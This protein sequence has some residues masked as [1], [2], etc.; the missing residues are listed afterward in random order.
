MCIYPIYFLINAK[1][2]PGE[3]DFVKEF[4][5]C[6]YNLL[7]YPPYAYHT[8]TVMRRPSKNSPPKLYPD[9]Q[10]LIALAREIV[11]AA[12]RLERRVWE[13][14]MDV[15]I[16]KLLKTGRQEALDAA[17]DHLFKSEI[18]AYDALLQTIEAASESCTLEHDGVSYDVL[19]IAAP[20]LAWTRFAIP[21]GPISPDIQLALTVQLT[22]HV[23]APDV[24]VFVAPQLFS[25]D[26]LPYSHT[27]TSVVTH[28]LAK[29]ALTG[30]DYRP[31]PTLQETPPFLADTRY[32]LAAVAAPAGSP[33]FCWQTAQNP[34]AAVELRVG[35]LKAWQ[36]QGGANVAR[37]LPGCGIELMLPE[38][39]FAACRKADEKIRPASIRAAVHYLTHTLGIEPSSLRAVIAPFGEM[40][41]V[42][43]ASEFR[44]AFATRD[45]NDIV[46]GIVWPLYGQEEAGDDY[47]AEMAD[48]TASS[49]DF[50]AATP[51][52]AIDEILALLKEHGVVCEKRHQERF[53]LEYCDDCGAPLF[54]D[55]AGEL[56]HAEMPEDAPQ[57]TTHLH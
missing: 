12:S 49:A 32:L 27:Q 29:N 30:A 44:V 9:S 2:F 41:S 16:Q 38:S 37:L 26:Q 1:K 53:P 11:N 31:L 20:V 4:A 19:L 46:Y 42:A 13:G 36:E 17:L 34:L 51:N 28:H 52:S 22:A 57:G 56:V 23:L 50:D 40:S 45:S 47:V 33:L 6:P 54:A 3:N 8:A 10:R 14:S 15:V 39:F 18:N 48:D 25:I 5:V 43:P 24:R 7:K 55:A 21:H 35:A